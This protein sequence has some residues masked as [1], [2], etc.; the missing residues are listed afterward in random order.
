MSKPTKFLLIVV[1]VYV[2]SLALGWAVEGDLKFAAFVTAVAIVPLAV[3]VL[4]LCL[5]TALAVLIHELGHLLAGALVGFQFRSLTVG[6]L[7]WSRY[8]GTIHFEWRKF[9]LSGYASMA[10]PKIDPRLPS[11]FMIFVLGGPIA[12]AVYA[13]LCLGLCFVLQAPPELRDPPVAGQGEWLRAV[14]GLMTLTACCLFGGFAIPF[15]TQSG[16]MTD[17]LVL[18]RLARRGPMRNL[19]V[20]HVL[21][22]NEIFGGVRARDWN[23]DLV[24]LLATPTSDRFL[25]ARSAM[26]RY[27]H[28]IGRNENDQARSLLGEALAITAKFPKGQLLKDVA[29]CEAAYLAARIGRDA[30]AAE[31]LLAET[32]DRHDHLAGGRAAAKAAIALLR[33]DDA[34]ARDE[35]IKARAAF[36]ALGR[37]TGSDVSGDLER[38]RQIQ[39]TA[40]RRLATREVR[41]S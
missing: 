25:A 22:A 16:H 2:G 33:G 7:F 35:A 19:I 30:D 17:A 34:M 20:A 21:L 13:G 9:T 10:P 41:D 28:A 12:S 37:R 14:L 15:T 27:Y 4:A 8:G 23:P 32:T 26:L 6:P 29:Y 1:A 40:E 11:R 18:W 38:I 3:V 31:R 36:E 5:A 39:E 24:R